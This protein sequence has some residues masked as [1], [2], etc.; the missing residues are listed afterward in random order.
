LLLEL[1]FPT[2]QR[3]QDRQNWGRILQAVPSGGA[4]RGGPGAD[5]PGDASN[6]L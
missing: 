6:N 1:S 2:V 5:A 4:A 3:G